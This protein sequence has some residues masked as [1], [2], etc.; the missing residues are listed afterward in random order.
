MAKAADVKAPKLLSESFDADDGGW[1]DKLIADEDEPERATLWRLGSWAIAAVVALTLGLMSGQLPDGTKRADVAEAEIATQA[2]QLAILARETRQETRRIAAALDTLNSDRDRM[3]SRIATVEQN[4]DSVTGSIA[5]QTTS[6]K[7]TE[8]A[9]DKPAERAIAATAADAAPTQPAAAPAT[10][11]EVKQEPKQ[12]GKHEPKKDPSTK[13]VPKVASLQAAA[14]QTTPVQA[15]PQPEAVKKTDRSDGQRTA[16]PAAAP[17]NPETTAASASPS[18]QTVASPES[19]PASTTTVAK[20]TATQPPAPAAPMVITAAPLTPLPEQEVAAAA[21]PETPVD[22]T[23]FG[24]DL[25]GASSMT[26][27]RALWSGVRKAHP[28]QFAALR[29]VLAIRPS[30]NGLGLQVHVVAGP[31]PDAA[32]AARLCAILAA[33]DRDCE[34]ALFDGQ[35]LLPDVDDPN[36]KPALP[37]KPARRKQVRHDPAPATPAPPPSDSK[38]SVLSLLGVR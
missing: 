18:E 26:G 9:P 6:T 28:S 22:R 27:L 20:Q 30:K 10:A 11:Q 14:V 17:T 1:L 21:V 16:M 19:D 2:Q 23:Q 5:K 31:I 35:R 12:E 38:A 34:T 32:A 13:D 33:D 15:A 29:P 3:F 8:P 7:P 24:L 36:K 25:G 4:L 37:P